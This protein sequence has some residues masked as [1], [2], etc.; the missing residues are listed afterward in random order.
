MFC[1]G[2]LTSYDRMI[3]NNGFV[4]CRVYIYIY[5]ERERQP[6]TAL[7]SRRLL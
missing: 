5:R 4:G 3:M 6:L 1:I 7:I 2:Y